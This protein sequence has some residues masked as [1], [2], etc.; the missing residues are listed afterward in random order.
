MGEAG[1]KED[2]LE[3]LDRIE[4]TRFTEFSGFPPTARVSIRKGNKIGIEWA[5]LPQKATSH[6][7]YQQMHER[8]LQRL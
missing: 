4:V 2:A 7:A 1:L 8:C 3:T 5:F 6:L